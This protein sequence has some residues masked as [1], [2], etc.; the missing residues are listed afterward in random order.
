MLAILHI[1]NTFFKG[2]HCYHPGGLPRYVTT[3]NVNF[4]RPHYLRE[5]KRRR[6]RV[7]ISQ[8]D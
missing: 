6:E 5:K 4:L 3:E 2:A 8:L 1:P 7:S